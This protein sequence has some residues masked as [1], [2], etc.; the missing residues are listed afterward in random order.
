MEDVFYY[1]LIQK[2]F[3]KIQ[4]PAHTVDEFIELNNLLVN[5]SHFTEFLTRRNGK[6]IIFPVN[7]Y[8]SEDLIENGIKK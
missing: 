4:F 8:I 7:S 5:K 1:D 3:V 6:I 2:E